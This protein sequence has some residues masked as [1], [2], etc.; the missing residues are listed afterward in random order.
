[1]EVKENQLKELNDIDYSK[2][3]KKLEKQKTDFNKK[4]EEKVKTTGLD[5]RLFKT[6]KNK[7][8]KETFELYDKE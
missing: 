1:M 6:L 7:S 3:L 4:V 2:D 8:V 5:I